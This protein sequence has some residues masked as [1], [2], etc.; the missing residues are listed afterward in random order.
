MCMWYYGCYPF[1][2]RRWITLLDS[3]NR[4]GSCSVWEMKRLPW[5]RVELS[6]RG[7]ALLL[8]GACGGWAGEV[9]ASWLDCFSA[10]GG[11]EIWCSK[12]KQKKN[13]LTSSSSNGHLRAEYG[14]VCEIYIFSENSY[15]VLMQEVMPCCAVLWSNLCYWCFFE[16]P[17][18]KTERFGVHNGRLLRTSH[19]KSIR[20]GWFYEGSNHQDSNYLENTEKEILIAKKTPWNRLHS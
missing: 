3:N 17:N 16:Q 11:S 13:N 6:V 1:W 18:E 2:A 19:D 9:R 14:S 7:C 15:Y 5:M 4:N 8:T 20:Q 10:I 12:K